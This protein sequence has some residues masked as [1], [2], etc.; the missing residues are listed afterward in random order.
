MSLPH[1]LPLA[2]PDPAALPH[3]QRLCDLRHP[4]AAGQ[5]TDRLF[6]LAMAEVNAW[7][8][9][10]SPFWDRVLRA[11]AEHS[12]GAEPPL[13]PA[14][15]FKRHEVLS[16]P[17]EQVALRLTS[18]GTSGQKSQMFFDAWSIG[19]AQRMVAYI[20]DHYG[21]YA[22]HAP[23]D[24]LL[25]SY[26]PAPRLRVGTSFTN[27]Y[28][29][30]FAPA[31]RVTHALRHTG[32]AGAGPAHEFDPF[33]ALAAIE[34]A[35]GDAVPLRL[36]GFPAFL[37]ATLRRM[38]DLG[39]PP[40][41][42][43]PDSLVFLGGG[44]K[45]HADR[46][47]PK[48]QLRGMVSDLLGIPPARVRDSFGSVEH[49]VPVVECAHHRLHLP[50]WSRAA[51]RDVATLKA[52]GYGQRGFLHLTSPYITS[53]PA[54]SVLMGDVA[55]VHPAHECGC[56]A[57][58]DWIILHGRAGVSRNRSCAIAAAELLKGHA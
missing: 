38:R 51:A 57:D 4:Y 22:P 34:R 56:G 16:V 27:N 52:L 11:E 12:P 21:W 37:A 31:R 54:H 5:D 30:D 28:L 49:C 17:R 20:F 14:A 58:T 9:A 45:N 13:I 50:V 36:F 23:V 39:R 3:V 46:E 48:E 2:V 10:R 42:L 40:V 35:A 29:C 33:G 47:I 8:R 19:A 55:S 18:S 44:W 53:V 32:A 26:E 24:Y 43:H 6:D 15:F 1:D 7:H 41:E 25:F